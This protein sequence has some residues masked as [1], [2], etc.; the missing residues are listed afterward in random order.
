MI[1]LDIL[2]PNCNRNELLLIRAINYSLTLVSKSFAFKFC[3]TKSSLF[4]RHN[5]SLITLIIAGESIFFLPFVLARIFRPTL[6][7]VL[8]ITNTELGAYFSVYGI[9]A[10]ISYFLGGPLADKFPV[11]NLMS[12]ALCLTSLGG[13]VMVIIPLKDGLFILYG[14]W[15]LTTIL[16]FW[17]ALIRATREWGGSN[18]QGRAF[19]WLEGGRGAVAAL[20]GTLA[21]FVFSSF[22]PESMQIAD[23]S[24]KRIKVFQSVILLTSAITFISGALVWWFVPNNKYSR[25]SDAVKVSQ[26]KHLLKLPSLWLLALIIV[27]AYVSYKITD[28]FSLFAKEVFGYSEFKSAGFGTAA[29]WMRAVVAVIAG[30]VADKIKASYLISIC[31]AL[32]IVGGGLVASGLLEQ[33]VVLV[34]IELAIVMI[35]VYVV[36]ALYF[37]LIQEA[38]IPIFY[39]GTAVG[40]V[41]VLGFTPDIFMSPWMGY[42]LDNNPGVEGHRYVFLVLLLFAFLGFMASLLFIQFNKTNYNLSETIHV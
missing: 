2:N 35:G 32:T 4:T 39:T 8:D 28:D 14:F 17:G 16:L 23:I 10:M 34:I 21:L 33:I 19:G 15:G 3:M 1:K 26:I 24:A 31:F 9:V 41:S 22:T 36:R 38:N 6:L 27:C 11:R 29:L 25:T 30:F 13:L 5:I 42:L 7:L 18:F 12:L 20:L 40:I 37:T